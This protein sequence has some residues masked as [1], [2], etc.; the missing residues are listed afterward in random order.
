MG[1]NNEGVDKLLANVSAANSRKRA[2][3]SASTSARTRHAD[4]EGGRRLPDLPG[5][6]TTLASYVAVNISSPNT[7][8]LR[9]LQKD[10][11]LDAC[12]RN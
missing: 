3:S 9:E 1:F 7:K 8:N 12:W 4:R 10:E 11:A 2:A 5:R 6:S